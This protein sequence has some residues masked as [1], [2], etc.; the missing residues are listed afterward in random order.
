MAI[1]FS[2]TP[3][4]FKNT[5][6]AHITVT[7][8]DGEPVVLETPISVD[9]SGEISFAVASVGR[10][11]I[12]VKNND[13]SESLTVTIGSAV[14]APTLETTLAIGTVVS[15]DT[16]A[17]DI[18]DGILDLTLPR[19][20][21]GVP[22][23]KGDTGEIGLT[24]PQGQQG[25]QGPQ[26]LT[27]PTGPQGVKGDTGAQ[28][29]AGPAGMQWKGTWDA[30][31]DYVTDDA[32]Y[33]NGGSWFAA[34][35]PP[36]GEVPSD[37]STYWNPLALRGLQG[38]AGSDGAQG[39]QGPQGP[40][41]IQG[42]QGLTGLQGPIGLTGP[43]GAT[44]MDYVTVVDGTEARPDSP[45]VTWKGGTTKPVNAQSGDIWLRSEPLPPIRREVATSA[46]ATLSATGVLSVPVPATAQVG[47]VMIIN[48]ASW[49]Y[50]AG[51][52]PN[53]T[54]VTYT[55]AV[56]YW[57]ILTAADLGTSVSIPT[58]ATGAFNFG[59]TVDIWYAC[60]NPTFVGTGFTGTTPTISPVAIARAGSTVAFL[61]AGNSP[62]PAPPSGTGLVG[63]YSN[64]TG[65][66]S[67]GTAVI[68]THT[69]VTVMGT[70]VYSSSYTWY[71]FVACL[72]PL[73]TQS[74]TILL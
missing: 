28:G 29:M 41:G 31:T 1:P 13:G 20:A 69:A 66:W 50:T 36:V 74:R 15:G 25:I 10:Y 68:G 33:Y 44:N 5:S 22:G 9:S 56:V 49:N 8:W 72:P 2:W 52:V 43:A 48:T 38:P 16:A 24:G 51:T 57:K 19:G 14:P 47:D 67:D 7:Y 18:N 53:W 60:G 55:Y 37:S 65:S 3:T 35:D 73:F 17:A 46:N 71:W 27:G 54:R 26:G 34:G 62:Q 64:L 23:P 11:K 39:A 30:A 70:T 59:Y 40:Q 58:S 42:I 45:T 21:Q 61:Y 32:V 4:S 12:V 6:S 63:A